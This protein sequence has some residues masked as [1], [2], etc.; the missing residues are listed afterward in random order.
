MTRLP[1]EKVSGTI[2]RYWFLTP[3]L[4]SAK[5][6]AFDSRQKTGYGAWSKLECPDHRN[7]PLDFNLHSLSAANRPIFIRSSQTHRDE[8]QEEAMA[9]RTG[10]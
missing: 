7:C 1:G 3:F 10:R 9:Q 2:P 8:R 4:S 6:L 5:Q